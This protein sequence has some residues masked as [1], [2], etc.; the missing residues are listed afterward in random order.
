MQKLTSKLSY[1]RTFP[2]AREDTVGM[3]VLPV[4]LLVYLTSL[5]APSVCLLI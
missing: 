1:F 4:C 5:P 2:Q 3:H